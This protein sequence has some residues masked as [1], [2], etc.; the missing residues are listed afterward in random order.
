MQSHWELGLQLINYGRIQFI[1]NDF[2]DMQ[3]SL[4]KKNVENYIQYDAFGVS[5]ER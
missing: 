1:S 4:R 3:L 2:Q 5:I